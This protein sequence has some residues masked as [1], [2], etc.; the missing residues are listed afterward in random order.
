MNSEYAAAYFRILIEFAERVGR[1]GHRADLPGLTFA[2]SRSLSRRI[3][4]VFALANGPLKK[5]KRPLLCLAVL[6]APLLCM[7]SSMSLTEHRIAASVV[8]PR[9]SFAALPAASPAGT[10]PLVG[11]AMAPEAIPAQPEPAQQ[12]MNATSAKGFLEKNC[13]SCHGSGMRPNLQSVANVTV[14][15]KDLTRIQENAAFWERVLQKLQSGLEH[16]SNQTTFL[17]GQP[18]AGDRKVF[19][20]WLQE[21]LDRNAPLY[22]PPPGIHRLNR[23][24]YG[25]AV[26]DMLA[27][28]VDT[29]ALLPADDSSS[30]FDNIAR[31]LGTSG[32]LSAAYA[33]AGVKV[34]RLALGITEPPSTPVDSESRRKIFSC[35]PSSGTDELDCVRRI[36]EKLAT[37][38]F[39]R[40][41]T[42]DEIAFLMD[43]Y[44]QQTV[45]FR[46]L[47]A[48][49]RD[50]QFEAGID[51]VLQT[52]LF[53]R[54]FLYRVESEPSNARIG[55]A[56]QIA[57]IELA[58]RLSFFIWSSIPDEELLD[59]ANRGQ[60]H[61]PVVLER[62]TRR[63]LNDPRSS[64]LSQNFFGQW[65][66]LRWMRGAFPN[67]TELDSS[68]RQAMLREGELFFE[69]IIREN[70]N[71][72]DLLNADYTFV[73]ERLAKHYGMSNVVGDE[74]RRVTLGTAFDVRRGLLGKAYFLT[75]W[76]YAG[77][78]SIVFRGN[79]LMG[80][81]LGIR[82][83]DPPPNVP[84]LRNDPAN[85]R[86]LRQ[87]MELHN[88]SAACR[89]CHSMID[90]IGVALEN[91][92]KFGVWRTTDYGLPIDAT[93]VLLDGTR[94]SGPVDL[95]NAFVSRSDIFVQTLTKNL[96][97]YALGRGTGYQDM[98]VIRAI[99]RNASRNNNRFSDIV[100]GIVKSEPF[101]MNAKF[102]N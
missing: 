95:R 61:D 19:V 36:I 64:A 25:N 73:N 81:I 89:S 33:N 101:Q 82:A 11:A 21:E 5:L 7:A 23:T 45:L 94:V 79:A 48:L 39:R 62:E 83:P 66:G 88:T 68:L 60:L 58:S 43:V 50:R 98:P 85:P 6:G 76:G 37:Q 34:S 78:T 57:D 63:M 4:G 18:E 99:S 30:G 90:P 29:T 59:A 69:S 70:R 102:D 56:Y 80:T 10:L 65:L 46:P 44:R 52:I 22:L 86:T 12:S 9:V 40:P 96:M 74:F 42:A 77:R 20:A 27:V 2:D 1:R 41:A 54:R 24:E 38:A 35:R 84:E 100:M 53:D 32:L 31:T 87:S 75:I 8:A 72:V 55:Q 17:A 13:V 28:N 15:D 67:E 91:F 3:D 51:S 26:R 49:Q 92:D 47:T 97:T 93:T 71:V 16:T 14:D